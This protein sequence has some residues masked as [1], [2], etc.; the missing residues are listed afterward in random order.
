MPIVNFIMLAARCSGGIY[1]ITVAVVATIIL[2][3]EARK[4]ARKDT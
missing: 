2:I 4:Y 3:N 1:R